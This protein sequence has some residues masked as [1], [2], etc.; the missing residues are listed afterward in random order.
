MIDK[1]NAFFSIIQYQRVK[2]FGEKKC[3]FSIY[4]KRKETNKNEIVFDKIIHI[5][6]VSKNNNPR[7]AEFC[8]G[9]FVEVGGDTYLY[10]VLVA[11]QAEKHKSLGLKR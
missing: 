4:K 9:R 10:R 6:A 3:C 7:Q 8:E 5:F 2:N 11:A 1:S